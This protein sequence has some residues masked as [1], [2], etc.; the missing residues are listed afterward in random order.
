MFDQFQGMTNAQ[1]YQIAFNQ[2]F[3]RPDPDNPGFP[4][5]NSQRR[6]FLPLLKPLI[7]SL[8]EDPCILDVGAGS[9][10]VLELAFSD[11]TTGTFNLEEP[12]SLLL[13]QYL[14][15]LR[16]SGRFQIGSVYSG[17]V[18]DLYTEDQSLTGLIPENSQDLILAIHMIYQL[19]DFECQAELS[20]EE[21]LKRF[22]GFLYSRLKTGGHIFLVYADQEQSTSGYASAYYYENQADSQNIAD[23]MRVINKVRNR[24]L[25]TGNIKKWLEVRFKDTN[26]SCLVKVTPSLMYGNN[27][28]ELAIMSV[29]GELCRPDDQLFYL[30]KMVTCHEAIHANEGKI[31]LGI[32]KNSVSQKGMVQSNQPQVIAI[33]GKNRK[34]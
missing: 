13:E 7:K 19:S 10:E 15:R 6:D 34:E 27:T 12:N 16:K 21:D 3:L 29:V 32:E 8:P 17:I 18:Q 26:P 1:V 25:K 4:L 14:T 5:G 33:I 30:D 9:G 11:Q 2:Y 31:G 28:E 23:N 22:I 24:L 20:P